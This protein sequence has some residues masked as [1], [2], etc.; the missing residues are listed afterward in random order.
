MKKVADI[1]TREVV[2]TEASKTVI[3]AAKV[4]AAQG[5]GCL[6]VVNPAKKAVG[7]ITERDLVSRVLAESFDPTKILVTDVMT[8]PL[9]TV[10]SD[11]SLAKAAEVMVRY[12][13]RRLPVVDEGVLVGIITVT[14]L[15]RALSPREIGEESLSAI[16]SAISRRNEFQGLEPYR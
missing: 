15:A 3:D 9:W 7:I 16:T 1:M 11:L 6:L 10:S 8:T 4:M 12:K 5:V 13:V 2:T 14:D